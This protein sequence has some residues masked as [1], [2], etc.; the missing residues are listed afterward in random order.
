MHVYIFFYKI[1][2]GFTQELQLLAD[3]QR[4]KQW[5]R[6]ADFIKNHVC[7]H[8]HTIKMQTKCLRRICGI[9]LV[10]RGRKRVFLEGFGWKRSKVEPFPVFQQFPERDLLKWSW[11]EILHTEQQC[12]QKIICFRSVMTRLLSTG[13]LTSNSNQM[14]E[15][16][17]G[18]GKHIHVR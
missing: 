1:S 2:E 17:V 14:M 16:Q 11:E 5:M 13:W 18:L 7:F 12:L 8:L 4:E 10:L 3:T 9:F 15:V 6:S